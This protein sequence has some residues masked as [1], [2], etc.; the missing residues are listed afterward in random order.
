MPLADGRCYQHLAISPSGMIAASYEGM[1]HLINSSS[2]DLVDTIDAH[3]GFITD[4]QW[5]PKPLK[6]PQG[7]KQV[8]ATSSKDKRVRL[9]NI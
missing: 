6:T 3:D 4:M 1:V 2:G 9:W 5:C 8:L 7:I